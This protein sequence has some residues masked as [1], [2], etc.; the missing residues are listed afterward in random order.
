M[1][2]WRDVSWLGGEPMDQPGA[3][4]RAAAA[5]RELGLS[6]LL[7]TGYTLEA[8]RRRPEATAALE[9][10]DAVIAGPYVAARRSSS[11][12]WIGSDNQKLHLLTNRFS[13]SDFQSG[14]QGASIVIGADEVTVSGWPDLVEALT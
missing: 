14:W 10:M 4:A 7:F 2:D 6:Q 1:Q 5:L 9:A 12:R 13:A 11:R 3:V 8:L